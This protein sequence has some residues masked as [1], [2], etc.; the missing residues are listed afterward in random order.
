MAKSPGQRSQHDALD[1][2]TVGILRK[3]VNWV[4]DA[5]IRGFFDTLDQEWLVKFVEHRIGDRRV[6]RLIQRWLKAGILEDGKWEEVEEGTPQGAVISPI[7]ANLYLHYVLDLWVEAWREK[8]ANGDV[9][10]VRYADDFVMGF[11]HKEEADK[12]LEQLRERM[13][14]FRLELHPDKT[15]LI[16][17]G[18]FAQSN[19]KQRGEGNP[20]TFNFLGF[21]HI[22]G[23][24]YKTGSFNVKR[25]TIGK[26]MAAKLKELR[27]KLRQRMHDGVPE[28]LK[29]LQSVI[30]G[31]F[32]YHAIPGNWKRMQ[33]FR[34]EVARAWWA[35]LRRRS[36]RRRYT[37]AT[38]WERLGRLLPEVKII[39]P[40]PLER[41]HAKHPR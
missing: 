16:E 17:F 32:Q 40:S 19:R 26:K 33:A 37:W 4:L 29:W 5:D 11:Q 34:K 23:K 7:L 8:V 3:K 6:V 28:T 36:Q 24:T 18:R 21:T 41:F 35:Q 10:I 1:A 25:Q 14:K 9:V 27:Q 2:L 22:C 15:R 12:F 38:F 20:E 13:R 30:R 39:H 31:Y